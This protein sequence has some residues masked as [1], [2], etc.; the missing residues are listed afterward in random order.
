MVRK[1]GKLYLTTIKFKN[2][3]VIKR[4]E[5]KNNLPVTIEEMGGGNGEKG[6]QEEL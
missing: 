5:I 3:G 2:N 6:F 1:G 4:K